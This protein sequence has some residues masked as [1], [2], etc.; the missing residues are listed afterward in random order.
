MAKSGITLRLFDRSFLPYHHMSTLIL[1]R[2][3]PRVLR[4]VTLIARVSVLACL[5]QHVQGFHTTANMAG[6]A[7]K[8][9]RTHPNYELLYHPGVSRD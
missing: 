8:K 5:S 9:Q 7:A 3:N 6:P 1:P 4:P 2:L